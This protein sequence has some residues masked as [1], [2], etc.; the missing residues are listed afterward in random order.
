MWFLPVGSQLIP[1]ENGPG[2]AS[3]TPRTLTRPEQTTI[4]PNHRGRRDVSAARGTPKHQPSAL[5]AA[6]VSR[7]GRG[8]HTETR[9]I[10][11]TRSRGERGGNDE[12]RTN[13]GRSPRCPPS[14][15]SSTPAC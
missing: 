9:S 10:G 5:S 8:A 1:P 2:E 12:T 3:S 6:L 13:R 15:R 11:L 14:P 7:G 4:S